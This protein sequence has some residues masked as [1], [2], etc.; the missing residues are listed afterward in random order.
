M[1]IPRLI[2]SSILERKNIRARSLPHVVISYHVNQPTQARMVDPK[3]I[4]NKLA[5]FQRRLGCGPITSAASAEAFSACSW[6][7][8]V[9]RTR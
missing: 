9:S 5:T 4:R 6:G 2:A 8:V 1:P 3:A 7:S